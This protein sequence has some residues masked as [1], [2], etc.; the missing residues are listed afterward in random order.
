[1]TWIIE[2][3]KCVPEHNV[4]DLLPTGNTNTGLGKG[5]IWG[6]KEESTAIHS[7]ESVCFDECGTWIYS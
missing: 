2:W 3:F 7:K 5:A 1:M 4:T 6:L